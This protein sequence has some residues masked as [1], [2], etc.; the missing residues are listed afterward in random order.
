MLPL[1]HLS[2]SALFSQELPHVQVCALLA[3]TCTVKDPVG[4]LLKQKERIFTPFNDVL[5]VGTLQVVLSVLVRPRR[6]SWKSGIEMEG[7][8]TN[9]L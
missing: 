7:H 4:Q 3:V 8:E 9:L 2:F 6:L 1:S 5:S